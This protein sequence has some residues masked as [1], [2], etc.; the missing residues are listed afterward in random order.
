VGGVVQKDVVHEKKTAQSNRKASLAHEKS[1]ISMILRGL[2][3][4]KCVRSSK[5]TK[6]REVPLR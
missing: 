5:P 2:R 4:S 1:H 6:C 3:F